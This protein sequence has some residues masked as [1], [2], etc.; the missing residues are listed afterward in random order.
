M[1]LLCCVL[2]QVG[3]LVL[4]FELFI[5]DAFVSLFGNEVCIPIKMLHDTGQDSQVSKL[6]HFL[7]TNY[8]FEINSK[9]N[10]VQVCYI[11]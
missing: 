8:S 2:I 10:K 3:L 5:A 9:P 4:G 6:V 1:L 11:S 7:W